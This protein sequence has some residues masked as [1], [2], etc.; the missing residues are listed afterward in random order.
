[1]KILLLRG[2]NNY[3]N[4]IVKKYSTLEDYKENSDSFLEFTDINFNPND[5]I[6]TEL[7][8]GNNVQLEQSEPL[9]W[10]FL[11]TP[12][13]LV[14]YET[15]EGDSSDDSDDVEIIKYRWFVTES[16]RTR[17]GQ[18]KIT[19]KRDVMA[20]FYD[21]IVNSPCYIEKATIDDLNN[22]LLYNSENFNVNQIKT[23]ENL[24]K[25]RSGVAWVVGYVSSKMSTETKNA[26]VTTIGLNSSGAASGSLVYTTSTSFI[27]IYIQYNGQNIYGGDTGFSYTFNITSGLLT[28][29][30]N[31]PSWANKTVTMRVIYTDM[32]PINSVNY[33]TTIPSDEARAHLTDA[34]YDMFC[35]PYGQ[36]LL[37][38]AN[39]TTTKE[40][41]LE[42][43]FEFSKD[44]GKESIYDIQLLP[45]CPRQDMILTGRIAESFGTENADY[46]YIYDKNNVKKSIMIWCKKSTDYFLAEPE[47]PI[48]IPRDI[49]PTI[50]SDSLTG[51]GSLS[52]TSL[53]N[54]NASFRIENNIFKERI[55]DSITLFTAS[56][57]SYSDSITT[58]TSITQNTD[59]GVVII[60]YTGT[61]FPTGSQN[62]VNFTLS[63]KYKKYA[64][65]LY[66]DYK[67]SNECDVYRLTSPNYCGQFEWS[68]AKSSGA[69]PTF[70]VD[71]TYKP[72][73]PYIH[74]SPIFTKLYGQDFDDCRGL[75]CGGDF[76]M[77][78][79][80][81]A[82]TEYQVQNK[83]YQEMFDR[84]ILNF[85]AQ[86]INAS[87]QA[88]LQGALGIVTGGIAGAAGGGKV[89]GAYGAA[90]GGAIGMAAGTAGMIGDMYFMNQA[91]DEQ[92]DF[93]IDMFNYSLQNIQALPY[94][95][96][97]V[98][99]YTANNKIFPMVEYYTCKDV[100]KQ[101]LRDKLKY[102]GMTVMI[103]GTINDYIDQNEK[104]F[105]KGQIIRMPTLKD[106]DHVA[107]A[108]YNEV[109]KGVYI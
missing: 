43:A 5:G 51:T 2:F 72:F 54:T 53:S 78:I 69:N 109:N 88:A 71:F 62:N 87:N 34:P 106:D 64:N 98:A 28:Y 29:N 58:F 15:D 6:T 39:I 76:S 47:N 36:I 107:N 57:N 59:T 23:S 1:M 12:D 83:T 74:I 94:G 100:E 105:I 89:G 37:N 68:L 8:V 82:W 73:Q 103:T 66:L 9:S 67:V 79:V 75:I 46:N 38:S 22:P 44:L 84:E 52:R 3:F 21:E 20:D 33:S 102:N 80:T 95:L 97:K 31:V 101:A 90:A 27:R 70:D 14:C 24:I 55:V 11:G 48:E 92:R 91:Y 4:R 65:P 81:D 13:Y 42:I 25:D 19:L 26:E 77:P 99:A 30:I 10:E 61:S 85:D 96:S 35:I 50:Y 60:N 49:N 86:R 41:A 40:A 32:S 56:K 93:K 17:A 108:I 104:R 18:Y 16:I 63:Y 7:V 45:Y